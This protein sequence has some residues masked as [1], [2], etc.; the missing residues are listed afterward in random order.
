VHENEANY[1]YRATAGEGSVPA[2]RQHVIQRSPDAAPLPHQPGQVTPDQR[3]RPL[4]AFQDIFYAGRYGRGFYLFFHKSREWPTAAPP[5][6]SLAVPSAATHSHN[7][8][9]LIGHS[10]GTS[11]T[12]NVKQ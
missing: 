6:R 10:I 8:P 11:Q 1:S 12:L 7:S 3:I 9:D 5:P 2:Q 4:I